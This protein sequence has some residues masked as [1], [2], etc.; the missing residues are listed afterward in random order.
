MA[1][2]KPKISDASEAVSIRVKNTG[3][4]TPGLALAYSTGTRAPFA[5]HVQVDYKGLWGR[6]SS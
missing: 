1:D 2:V 3:L 4:C 6:Q 5:L